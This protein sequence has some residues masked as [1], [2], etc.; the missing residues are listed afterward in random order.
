MIELQVQKKLRSAAGEMTLDLQLELEPGKLIALYG[1]S[2][3]GK[4]S[5]LRI[6]AGLLAPEEGRIVVGGTT[7][8][9]TAKGI[10]LPPQ[11]RKVGLVFQ[12]YA[13]FPNMSVK[14]NLL[15]ALEKG[16]DRKIV[17][18]LIEIVELGALQDRK[19][20]TLSGGQR[21]RVAL[22][23]ALVQRPQLLLLDE[24]LSALDH[25][26]RVKLQQHILQVHREFGLSTLLISHDIAEI[27][28]MADHLLEIDHG[29]IV[30]QGTPAEVFAYQELSGKFQFT[31]E[32]VGLDKQDFL[33][34]LAILVGSELVKV[35]VDEEEAKELSLGNKVVVASK[36]FNPVIRKIG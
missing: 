16:Q 27:L 2:G 19:P 26:M 35:V 10:S 12:D 31:G 17:A 24:P 22:A 36:A 33:V 25:E 29:R 34:I 1:K 7:W 8:L 32:I 21:Q 5:L 20:D 6:L 3:A 30:R 14:E 11:K 9:D 28:K 13:L 23:R 4:T 18:D 15:F